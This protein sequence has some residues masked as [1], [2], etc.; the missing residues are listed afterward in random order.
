MARSPSTAQLFQNVTNF[1]DQ[2]TQIKYFWNNAM[3]KIETLCWH[4]TVILLL[5]EEEA[6]RRPPICK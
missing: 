1:S 5:Q 4:S 3:F 6:N 2:I